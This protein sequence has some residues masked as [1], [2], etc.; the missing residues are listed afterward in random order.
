MN[1]LHLAIL[2]TEHG[3]P[4]K[5]AALLARALEFYRRVGFLQYAEEGLEAAAAVANATGS[6]H[7]AGFL[8]GAASRLR[9]QS[10]HAPVAFLADLRDRE[11]AT[12]RERL[13]DVA[14]EAALA[15]GYRAPSAAAME[16][17]IGFLSG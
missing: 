4:E 14:A 7:E 9:E 12:I 2:E 8:L 1:E 16:R 15:E 6:T 11:T 5:A 17:A 10:G 13:G 3:R